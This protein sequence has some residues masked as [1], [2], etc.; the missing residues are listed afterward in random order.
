[1]EKNRDIKFGSFVGEKTPTKAGFLQTLKRGK[2]N[3]NEGEISAMNCFSN[4]KS[5]FSFSFSLV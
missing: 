4:N 3:T 1:M 5:T 2:W